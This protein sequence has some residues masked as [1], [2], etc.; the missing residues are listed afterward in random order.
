MVKSEF[1]CLMDFHHSKKWYICSYLHKNYQYS[2]KSC[3]SSGQLTV[4]S[5]QLH[6]TGIKAFM[7]NGYRLYS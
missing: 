1:F 2:N 7:L 4:D 5:G 3:Y 6:S